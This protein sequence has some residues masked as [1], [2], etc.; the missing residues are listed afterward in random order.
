VSVAR[1]IKGTEVLALLGGISRGTLSRYIEAGLVPGPLPGTKM[2]DRE[3][4][5]HALDRRSGLIDA[6]ADGELRL[7]ERAKAWAG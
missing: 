1:L 3:A 2:Y 4:I 7:I 5:L 6:A